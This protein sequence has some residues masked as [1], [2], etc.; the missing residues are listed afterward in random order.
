MKA[1]YVPPTKAEIL[2]EV[3]GNAKASI[4]RLQRAYSKP[5]ANRQLGDEH[6]AEV[7]TYIARKQAELDALEAQQ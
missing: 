7:K 1:A 2:R 3:I 5:G 6:I 4:E